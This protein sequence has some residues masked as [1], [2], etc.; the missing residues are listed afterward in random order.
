MVANTHLVTAMNGTSPRYLQEG[1]PDEIRGGA[2]RRGTILVRQLS[3]EAE[4]HG[5]DASRL[6]VLQ[7]RDTAGFVHLQQ[8]SDG[9]QQLTTTQPLMRRHQLGDVSRGDRY[10]ES[11]VPAHDA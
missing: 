6:A 9:H 5:G 3:P 4:C 7:I 1:N 2:Q 8:Q 10:V 11:V